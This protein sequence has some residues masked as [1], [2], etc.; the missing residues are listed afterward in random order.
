MI[1]WRDLTEEA[2]IEAAMDEHG[3][4]ATASV[5]YC[6]LEAYGGR[7]NPEYRFWLFLKRVK[8]EH[9]GWA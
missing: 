7:E 2:A 3:K 4:D 8:R 1:D 5:A 6:A 9:I